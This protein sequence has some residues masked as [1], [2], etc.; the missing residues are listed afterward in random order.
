MGDLVTCRAYGNQGTRPELVKVS[1][2][3]IGSILSRFTWTSPKAGESALASTSA[4][5]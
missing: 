1:T 4:E 2:S 3:S 5:S